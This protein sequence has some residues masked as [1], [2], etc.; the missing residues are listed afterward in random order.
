MMTEREARFFLNSLPGAGPACKRLF[1]DAFGCVAK[2][3]AAGRDAWEKMP[4]LQK[5]LLPGLALWQRGQWREEMAA[6]AAAGISV[7][8]EEDP[9]YPPLLKT[10]HDPPICLYVC[11]KKEVLAETEMALAVVGSR[12]CSSYGERMAGRF[13]EEASRAGWPV[14]SG[15]ARGVDTAAHYGTL[16]AGGRTIAVLGGGLDCIYPREN[17]GLATRIVKEGG[18][19]ISEFPMGF[20]PDRRS[21]PMRNRIISGIC[22]G[23][24]V[25]EAGKQ[26]GS[27]IT[28]A[29]ALE[30]G[31]TVFAV[32][33][34][35]DLPFSAG[36]HTLLK[37][38]A[39]LA[40]SLQD[41]VAEY[42][43]LP[44][45]QGPPEE[46]QATPPSLPDSPVHL[47]G[48]EEKL[49]QLMTQR[50]IE[51]IDEL[52]E[53]SGEPVQC[54]SAALISLETKRLVRMLPGRQV[55]L[56]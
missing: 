9:E 44:G 27:L 50:G 33:G 48:L 4:G 46:S 34:R 26:S 31:R 55:V 2:G 19:L 16:E 21:F 30:Q 40:E 15:L 17:I 49:W 54:V 1:C 24:L 6:A 11:G 45:L 51:D 38:G 10:I 8:I 42:T 36:C 12:Y 18:A 32:P 39:V 47:S 5:R 3:L 7:L 52:A 13:A 25:V 29:M 23:T 20:R 43:L 56:R 28:A 53:E 35:A 41:L 14:V 37:D 22:R